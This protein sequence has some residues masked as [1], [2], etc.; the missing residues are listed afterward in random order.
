MNRESA[1]FLHSV[2]VANNAAEWEF[3]CSRARK[4]S[5]LQY[6]VRAYIDDLPNNTVVKVAFQNEMLTKKIVP[7]RLSGRI[8]K[9]QK[10]PG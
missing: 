6:T 3:P 5:T 10:C 1:T 7:Q 9:H 8:L 4:L 2:S